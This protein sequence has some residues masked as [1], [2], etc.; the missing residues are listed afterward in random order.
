M[1]AAVSWWKVWCF[2]FL[3]IFSFTADV[4]A[5]VV[6]LRAF[7][8]LFNIQKWKDKT[9]SSGFRS[10]N[11][12]VLAKHFERV[13]SCFSSSLNQ[14]LWRFWKEST[15]LVIRMLASTCT[16]LHWG[17]AVFSFMSCELF[18]VRPVDTTYDCQVNKWNPQSQLFMQF[19]HK[20]QKALIFFPLEI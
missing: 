20:A 9:G 12:G 10:E 13:F 5:N 4:K 1:G 8:H 6:S 15:R 3:C 7:V 19:A 16:D 11:N 2:Y 17:F 14:Q 18:L